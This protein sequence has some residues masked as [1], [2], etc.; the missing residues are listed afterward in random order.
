MRYNDVSGKLD[1]KKMY[2]EYNAAYFDNMLPNDLPIKWFKSKAVGGQVKATIIRPRHLKPTVL[3]INFLK[4]SN[5]EKRTEEQTRAIMLHEMIHVELFVKGIVDT[6]GRDKSHGYEFQERK[7]EL[8]RIIGMSIPDTEEIGE[9][10]DEFAAQEKP[11]GFIIYKKGERCVIQ[12][13][14]LK[15]FKAKLPEIVD[16]AN[17]AMVS[18]IEGVEPR[19]KRMFTEYIIGTVD[20]NL[21]HQHNVKRNWKPS[22]GGGSVVD[23]SI[24]DGIINNAK[25]DFRMGE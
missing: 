20:T 11:H 15:N 16:Y 23:K 14:N 2:D 6:S 5:L 4:I 8:E 9:L 25:I 22:L 7:V 18:S 19:L 12:L 24:Y 3:S 1:L 21:Y 13:Y 10:S 17:D